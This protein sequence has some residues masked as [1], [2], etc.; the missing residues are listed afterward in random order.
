VFSNAGLTLSNESLVKG[1]GKLK[2]E[3]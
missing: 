3:N 2:T 1:H